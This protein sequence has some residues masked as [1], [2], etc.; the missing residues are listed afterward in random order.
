[1]K[2]P[3]IISV[4]IICLLASLCGC[5]KDNAKTAVTSGITFNAD[6]EYGDK[7]YSLNCEIN[8]NGALHA[9]VIKPDT[10][11][12]M[13]ISADNKNVSVEYMG[14]RYEKSLTGFPAG[15]AVTILLSTLRDISVSNNADAV[16]QGNTKGYDYEFS[17]DEKGLPEKLSVSLL[18]LTITFNNVEIKNR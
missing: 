1:M 10:I 15:N 2:K 3:L 8:D 9:T 13:E 6:I 16:K 4:V 12:G 5:A 18:K 11:K 7:E 14:L 17:F